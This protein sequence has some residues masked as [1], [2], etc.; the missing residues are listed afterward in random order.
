MLLDPLLIHFR[1]CSVMK[2]EK[3]PLWYCHATVGLQ[4]CFTLTLYNKVSK[5]KITCCI[6]FLESP[7][8]LYHP[9]LGIESIHLVLLDDTTSAPLESILIGGISRRVNFIFFKIIGLSFE[10]NKTCIP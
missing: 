2:S 4:S 6:Y 7:T 9:F 5:K 1:I 8:F 3:E 10:S